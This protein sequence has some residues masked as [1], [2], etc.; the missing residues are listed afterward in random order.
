MR[1]ILLIAF[2]FGAIPWMLCRPHL[3]VYMWSWLGYMNPHRLTWGVTY[4]PFAQ[5]AAICTLLPLVFCKDRQ[6]LP[7]TPLTV[8]W[9]LFIAWMAF[10]TQFA[11]VPDSA[12][13]HLDKVSKIHLIALVTVVLINTRKKLNQLVWVIVV[14]IGFHGVKGGFFSVIT[15]GAFRVWG[16]PDTNLADNNHLGV[17]LLMTLPLMYYLY[18]QA[19]HRYLRW[20]LA[21]CMALMAFGVAGTHSRGSFVA[22]GGVVLY[23]WWKSKRKVVT[24]LVLVMLV[25]L[26]LAFMPAHWHERMGTIA[27]YQE[28][29]S[30]MGRIEAWEFAIAMANHRLVG[31]GFRVWQSQESFDQLTDGYEARAAHSIYFGVMGDHGWPG[32]LMFLSIGWLGL[33]TGTLIIRRT[34]NREDLRWM[35]DLARMTQVGMAAYATGGAFLSLSYFDLYWHLVA[36]MVI[37]R[38]LMER[39]LAREPTPQTASSPGEAAPSP[40]PRPHRPRHPRPAYGLGLVRPRRITPVNWGPARTG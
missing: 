30:A 27:N 16:P 9:L 24:G 32:L 20:G 34:R 2:V 21:V 12:W 8:I 4:F 31:G 37:T 3:G 17:A 29:G 22:S 11:I 38:V 33:H 40:P 23:L 7:L 14:S 15:G 35:G 1:D 36:I 19:Q 28:D 18:Q 39:E 6:R 10:T 13:M 26:I 5:V 25:P